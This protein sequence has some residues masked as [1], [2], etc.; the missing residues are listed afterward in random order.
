MS[1]CA[2]GFE[3][4]HAIRDLL[5]PETL[6]VFYGTTQIVKFEAHK[7]AAFFFTFLNP[8]SGATDIQT[9]LRRKGNRV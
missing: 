9:M 8:Y 3:F 7:L 6:C 2:T 5:N 4:V 1:A